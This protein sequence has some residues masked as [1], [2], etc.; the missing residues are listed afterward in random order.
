[1]KVWWRVEGGQHL[2]HTEIHVSLIMESSTITKEP[3]CMLNLDIY[4]PAFQRN[5]VLR[6][7]LNLFLWM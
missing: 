3:I 6:M 1:V 7:S 5:G 4:Q 2:I